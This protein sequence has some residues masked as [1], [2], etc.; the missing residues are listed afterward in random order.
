MSKSFKKTC[1]KKFK[2]TKVCLNYSL[3]RISSTFYNTF[4]CLFFRNQIVVDIPI[5][6]QARGSKNKKEKINSN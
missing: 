1:N 3:Y 2:Y 4:F 6:E 5:L